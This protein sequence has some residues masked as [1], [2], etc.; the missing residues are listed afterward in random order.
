MIELAPHTAVMIYLGLTILAMLSIWLASHF[1]L[2]KKSVVTSK[3]K[4]VT[5]E[6]CSQVYLAAIEKRISKCPICTSYNES[7]DIAK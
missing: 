1:R 3:Q 7:E 5:C 6:Y 4:L 2:R